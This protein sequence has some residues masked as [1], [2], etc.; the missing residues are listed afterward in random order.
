VEVVGVAAGLPGQADAGVL[1]HPRQATGLADADT[2][3]E[4]VQDGEG[5]RLGQAA[6]EQGGP[7]AFAEAV[8]AGAAGETAPL[9]GR[10]VA[11]GDPEVAV[12]PL[13][14]VG[15]VRVLAAEV[16]EVIHSAAHPNKVQDVASTLP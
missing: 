12:A 15:T 8:L 16:L 2:F 5:C 13:A 11:E 14:V 6:V 1:V 3:V 7:L 9:L 4:V 10:A